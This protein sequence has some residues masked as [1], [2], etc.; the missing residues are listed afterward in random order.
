M[1]EVLRS[2]RHGLQAVEVLLTDG[3]QGVYKI[4]RI[5]RRYRGK[6]KSLFEQRL[7]MVDM[8]RSAMRAS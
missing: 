3:P 7:Q 2:F 4:Q 8:F 1:Y 6:N 5:C